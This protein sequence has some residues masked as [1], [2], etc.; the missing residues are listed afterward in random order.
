LVGSQI[1]QVDGRGTGRPTFG[2]GPT[3]KHQ[4]ISIGGP[5]RVAFVM[6]SRH[7]WLGAAA[8]S[9]NDVDLPRL[10]RCRGEESNPF[11]IGRPARI[12]R[13]HGRETE[14]E[15]LAAIYLPPP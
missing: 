6:L 2:G 11:P 14:L 13:L 12:A 3:R 5:A 8:L 15:P 9:R 10:E 7:A 1:K 4:P